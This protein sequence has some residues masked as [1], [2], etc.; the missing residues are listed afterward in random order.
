MQAVSHLILTREE[1][2]NLPLI[3]HLG[4][5]GIPILSYP[6]VQIRELPPA[7]D[8]RFE[9]KTLAEF[10]ALVFTSR[11]AVRASAGLA[12]QLRALNLPLA[13]VGKGTADEIRVVLG[14]EPLITAEKA[15]GDAL[16][17]DLAGH[18]TSKAPI[19]YLRGD[20]STGSFLRVMTELDIPVV[21]Q[22]VYRNEEPLLEQLKDIPAGLGVF[23]SPSAVARF[24][25]TNPQLIAAMTGIAIGPTTA[26]ALEQAGLARIYTSAHPDNSSLAILIKQLIGDENEA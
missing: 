8:Q 3:S 6:C 24:F 10:A 17:R 21:E 15:T 25:R 23:S 4:P 12:G 14:L 7:A 5:L 26:Q 1:E 9:G 13:A 22:V 16:A 18:L 19:L 11:R 20:L 2:D